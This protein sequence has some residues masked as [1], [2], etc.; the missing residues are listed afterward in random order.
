MGG[1]TNRYADNDPKVGIF[2]YTDEYE[3]IEFTAYEKNRSF[4]DHYTV[5][6]KLKADKQIIYPY[7]EAEWDTYSRGRVEYNPYVSS[8]SYSVFC[9]E[10]CFNGKCCKIPFVAIGM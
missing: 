9:G 1:K 8:N 5:W 3:I 6:K 4:E 10:Y 7:I 2:W